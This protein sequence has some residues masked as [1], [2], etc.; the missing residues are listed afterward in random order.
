MKKNLC[1]FLVSSIFFTS[2]AEE[3]GSKTRIDDADFFSEK[4][5][6]S[7]DE[8]NQVLAKKISSFDL[9]EGDFSWN[10]KL[11]GGNESFLSFSKIGNFISG[12]LYGLGQENLKFK[13]HGDGK[14]EIFD[15]D[16]DRTLVC[17][18]CQTPGNTYNFDPRPGRR[19]KTWRSGDGNVIDLLVAYTS[20]SKQK[21]N[22]SSEN[23]VEAFIQSALAG[24]N[25]VFSN[26]LVN[27]SL[28][29]VH[30][31][32]VK[33]AET[34]NP[35]I[36]LNRTANKSDGYLDELHTLRDQY[37]A[38]LV[39]LLISD[40]DGTIAGVARGMDYPSLDFEDNG[41]NVVVMDQIDAPSFSLL[42]EI[43]HN[44]G[45][46]HNRE[47][48][49][50]RGIPDTDSS[51]NSVF[52]AF[53]YGKRWLIG[54][55]GYRTIMAYDTE[56]SVTYANQVPFFSNP[57]IKYLGIP[58]GNENSE[59]NAKVLEKTIPYVANFR[60][61]L[62]Q[63]LITSVTTLNIPE[64]KA[65]SLTIRL[66]SKPTTDHTV[67]L[68]LGPTNEGNFSLPEPTLVFTKQNWN[69]PR[70]VQ[71]FAANDS[72]ANHGSSTLYLKSDSLPSSSVQLNEVDS[73]INLPSKKFLTGIITNSLGTGVAEVSLVFSGIQES[74]SSDE[75]GTF[76]MSFD[77][78]WSGSLSLQKAGHSF[79]PSS[80]WISSDSA[81][82][83]HQSFIASRS[84][85]LF[86]DSKANGNE[87]GS[88]WTDAYSDLS[89]ALRS[90]NPFNEV[91]VAEGTYKPGIFRSDYFLLPASVS[92]YGG[93][94]GTESYREQR[95]PKNR[96]T[97]LS[98]DIG[99]SG[100]SSDNTFHIVM[101]ENGSHLDGFTIR[102]ANAS[103]NYS[104]ERG[105]GGGI[106]ADG[107]S[108]SISNCI[109]SG[110]RARQRGGALF[111]KEAN[112]TFSNCSFAGNLATGWS[113]G[114]GY[115]GAIDLNQS[116]LV[117]D[118]CSFTNNVS[119]LEGGAVCSTDSTIQMSSCNFS[120]N[121]NSSNNGGGA[122]KII[123][124]SLSDSNSTYSNND[125]ASNG[126]A[127]DAKKTT[128]NLSSLTFSSNYSTYYGGACNLEDCN[129]SI[130][131]TSFTGNRSIFAGG[132]IY[133]ID[134][135]LISTGSHYSRNSSNTQGGAV[136]VKNG[137]WI[138]T[139]ASYFQN[140]SIF[141][142]GGIYFE[143][144]SGSI[145]ESN[146]TGNL[147]STYNGGG[148]V[149]LKNSSPSFTG[150]TFT[151]NSSVS[152]SG[153]AIYMDPSSVPAIASCSF[154]SN[155][156]VGQFG[157]GGA[158]Y[159]SGN[160]GMHI[161][162]SLF[163]GNYAKS[164]GA[165]SSWGASD[166]TFSSC[167]FIANEANAT[168]TSEGG[169]ALLADGA[170]QTKF[171]NCIISGNKANYRGGFFKPDGRTR[172]V[173]CTL[174]GNQAGSEGGIAILFAGNSIELENSIL[175]KNSAGSTG[176]DLFVNSQ[177]V[178]AS[179]SLFDPAKSS[180]TL[181][182]NNNFLNDP[183]FVDIDGSDGLIGTEDD[184]YNLQP[185]SPAIDQANSSAEDY[186]STD[187]LGKTRFGSAPDIGAFEYRI[188]SAPSI[189][190]G[191][192]YSL[193][194]MED[195]EL[196]FTFLAE[197]GDLDDLSWSI[198]SQGSNGIASINSENGTL[199]Y[200]PNTN[201]YGSDS[202]V[203]SVSDGQLS[204]STTISI[205]I[206]PVDDPPILNSPLSDQ[207]M[208]EDDENL[209][210]DLS[211]V[212]VDVDLGSGF[213]FSASSSN[214]SL[215]LPIIEGTSLV[216]SLMPNKFGSSYVTTSVLS[217]GKSIS[218]E[219]LLTVNSVND[220][221]VFSNLTENEELS[222]FENS[223]FV[224]DLNASDQDE[225]ILSF[226]IS[227]TDSSFFECNASSGVLSFKSSP[228]FEN[229]KDSGFD[230]SYEIKVVV[231]DPITSS[232]KI[233]L[234]VSILD[235]DENFWT[236]AQNLGNGWRNYLWFGTYYE[237]ENGWLYHVEH[238]WLFRAG[239]STQSTWFYDTS[240]HWVWTNQ[241]HYPFFFRNDTSGWLFYRFTDGSV[242][243]FYDFESQA[244]SVIP[245]N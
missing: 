27:A 99:I 12:S 184:D 239:L 101:P 74:I 199:S 14:F 104:D 52:K 110:N 8:N 107:I 188:N 207:T 40:G 177:F 166:L 73:G 30:L 81:S 195:T 95:D 5:S 84:N 77:S 223:S 130:K 138:E 117:L 51:N 112:A 221:P 48:A 82:N 71:V 56:N 222:V 91:W 202:L 206:N 203:L 237:L 244:W 58:L 22:L 69:L 201:W 131:K 41:F 85:V 102:D 78:D 214:S 72:N 29:L 135:Y 86:V 157:Y 65:S 230:N 21:Q 35:S 118:S 96:V 45:C 1:I 23:E 141:E 13:K 124:G 196:N 42:H 241:S 159:F 235:Q 143:D 227:G 49:M 36:D 225:D 152:N 189:S 236:F 197:D 182:G 80:L 224:L 50:N 169:V 173:N 34:N 218:D 7:L 181:I 216:L 229:P 153:G 10:G 31:V 146:F 53:N 92:V 172:I 198:V 67:S 20:Q 43:G 167:R 231:S 233:N 103:E 226:S 193:S 170:D 100:Q 205:T 160:S 154:L 17:G 128:L 147:N 2:D 245:R 15:I 171:I 88:S 211:N 213:V 93:F 149:A 150:S 9:G 200:A 215:V 174:V 129:A 132:G 122:I 151:S 76:L 176:D 109:I 70:S 123:G 192:T 134:G 163:K 168:T 59:D 136:S 183:L 32:E 209:S 4:V 148:A 240:L 139:N 97:V 116:N 89:S 114:F 61:S 125:S 164:G 228:D 64:G 75:N 47:D 39:T 126:G 113:N 16:S 210:V 90:E 44:M 79:N 161:K 120:N 68:S 37:G 111:L 33:Y 186:S 105:K 98:G 232:T 18:G 242:R 217:D 24:S 185:S 220:A 144:S 208:N 3:I 25:L 140:D 179:H 121:Q 127:I 54:D 175:W 119:D 115:A 19:A 178:T 212:F 108:F 158:I 190:V 83:I 180:E 162:N 156:T 137:T 11:L 46:R 155:Y 106:Y 238:G 26:S 142:G 145:N 38:D 204:V 63:G 94:S 57:S 243:N 191:S 194:S 28:R 6:F 187:F 66:A 62:V 219:F 165:F 60:S 234:K 133:M 87:D 55:E